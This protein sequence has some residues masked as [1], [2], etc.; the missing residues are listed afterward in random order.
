MFD[1]ADRIRDE[2]D[3]LVAAVDPHALDGRRARRLFDIAVEIEQRAAALRLLV[4]GRLDETLGWRGEGDRSSAHYVARKTGTT[5]RDA[6]GAMQTA[7]RLDP[8]GATADALRSGELS[9][10]QASEITAACVADPHA[11]KRLVEQAGREGFQELRH[12]CRRVKAAARAGEIA[13]DDAIRR[14]RFLR[15]WTDEDGAGRGEWKLAPE[16]QAR[17][18]ARLEAEARAVTA[19]SADACR[20]DALVQLAECGRGGRLAPTVV[21]LR[22]DHAAFERGH[23]EPDEIC[24][25]EGVGPVPVA[26]ARNLSTRAVVH[27]LLTE[28][29]D[30]TRVANLGATS[31]PPWRPPSGSA[32]KPASSEDVRSASASKFIT[33]TRLLRVVSPASTTWSVAAGGTTTWRHTIPTGHHPI[34]RRPTI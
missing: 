22:V 7:Q 8:N 33:R 34:G 23:T 18:L 14:S 16:D 25:I 26:T 1:M 29:T 6:V 32:I 2:L 5:L 19:E 4:A 20:A 10:Q 28:G 24:E 17:L 30:V 11:E 12:E 3:D 27:A 21:H 15:T 9:A 13:H 31:P